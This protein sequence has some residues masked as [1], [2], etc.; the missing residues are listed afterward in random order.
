MGGFTGALAVSQAV[1]IASG[2]APHATIC[3]SLADVNEF[4]ALQ[5]PAPGRTKTGSVKA[6]TFGSAKR[7]RR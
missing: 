7:W 3:G 5:G 2:L 1:R 4:K 6:G